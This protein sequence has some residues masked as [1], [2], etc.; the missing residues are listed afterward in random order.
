MKL[1]LS[2]APK[3]G[4]HVTMPIFAMLTSDMSCFVNNIDHD[5]L[6]YQKPGDQNPHFYALLVKTGLQ[7]RVRT[8]G[9]QK[10]HLIET[11]L[12]ST[13]NTLMSKKINEFLCT[14]NP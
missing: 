12:L 7:I 1:A 2:E 5:Q 10:N 14:I 11:V 4:F 3:T 9:T 6:A 8:V 13:Q